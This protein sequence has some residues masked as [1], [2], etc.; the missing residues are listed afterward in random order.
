MWLWNILIKNI[1]VSAHS[2][3][4][5]H[6]CLIHSRLSLVGLHFLEKLGAQH[7]TESV[8]CLPAPTKP[9]SALLLL[10]PQPLPETPPLVPRP[11]RRA[12]GSR[13]EWVSG[14]GASSS[15][16]DS[17]CH[18]THF[19]EAPGH[20]VELQ[21]QAVIASSSR[22]QAAA[23]GAVSDASSPARNHGGTPD[24]R[25]PGPPNPGRAC[26]HCLE[27]SRL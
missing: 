22:V 7:Q 18:C 4:S 1:P 15:Q 3:C 8:V 25:D 10:S 11:A 17:F 14:A 2:G 12:R 24:T 19:W 5:F 23:G 26:S 13:P 27:P 16:L 6:W 20:T 9:S 21:T